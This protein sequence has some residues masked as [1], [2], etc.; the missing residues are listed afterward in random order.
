[1]LK[2]CDKSM[3]IGVREGLIQ[4]FID[5]GVGKAIT[6][7]AVNA[8]TSLILFVCRSRLSSILPPLRRRSP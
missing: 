3:I 7:V 1:M 8:Y 5:N 6:E 4:A 2:I